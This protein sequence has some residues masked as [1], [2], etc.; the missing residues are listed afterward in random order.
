MELQKLQGLKYHPNWFTIY[1]T[2]QCH[3]DCVMYKDCTKEKSCQL[4]F[5]NSI[6]CNFPFLIIPFLL[7]FSWYLSCYGKNNPTIMLGLFFLGL[8]KKQTNKQKTT[9]I[10]FF[11]VQ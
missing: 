5:L 8:V 10:Y 3:S 7:S 6:I 2:L 9:T 4:I 1:V 11:H